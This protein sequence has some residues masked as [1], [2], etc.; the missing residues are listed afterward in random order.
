MLILLYI[1]RIGVDDVNINESLGIL[2][3][4]LFYN[5]VYFNRKAVE[6][7]LSSLTHEKT[8]VILYNYDLFRLKKNNPSPPDSLYPFFHYSE[9]FGCVLTKLLLEKTD[10]FGD[11]IQDFFQKL[12][13][14]RSLKDRK[15]V[16]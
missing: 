15:S 7:R 1:M 14:K 9:H 11:A 4:S 16:V 12:E 8:D 2:Y 3:D 10:F 13:D 6:T 5:I